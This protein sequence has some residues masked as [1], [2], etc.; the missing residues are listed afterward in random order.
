MTRHTRANWTAEQA[1]QVAQLWNEGLSPS[2]IAVRV[3][4]T[5]NSVLGK[6]YRLGLNGSQETERFYPMRR[7]PRPKEERLARMGVDRTPCPTCGVRADIGCS[8]ARNPFAFTVL[9]GQPNL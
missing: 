1:E 3:G 8:H 5:R 2:L 9:R 7:S 4:K 6:I